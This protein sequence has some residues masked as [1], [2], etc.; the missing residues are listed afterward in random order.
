MEVASLTP[1]ITI[2]HSI[3]TSTN[4][5]NTTAKKMAALAGDGQPRHQ[6]P[7]LPSRGRLLPYL[8]MQLSTVW[9]KR[10]QNHLAG[11]LDQFTEISSSGPPPSP[12]GPRHFIF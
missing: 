6:S 7:C 1:S 2:S 4:R 10:Q 9:L 12:P 8:A 3:L 11:L 5:G